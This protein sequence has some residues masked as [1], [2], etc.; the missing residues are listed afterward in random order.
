MC[1]LREGSRSDFTH[2]G[3]KFPDVLT[4]CGCSVSVLDSSWVFITDSR[5][6]LAIF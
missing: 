2:K 3:N 5:K 6:I 1:L 4:V